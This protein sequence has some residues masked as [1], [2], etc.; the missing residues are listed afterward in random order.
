MDIS[1]FVQRDETCWEIPAKDTMLV[2][3]CIKG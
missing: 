1:Q 3:A 2:P